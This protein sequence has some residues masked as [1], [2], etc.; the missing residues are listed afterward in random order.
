VLRRNNQW[1]CKKYRHAIRDAHAKSHGVLRGELTVSP[2]LPDHLRQGFFAKPATY[3]VVARFSTTAGAIRS[4]TIRGV[5]SNDQNL[6]MA[7]GLVT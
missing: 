4:D 1:A 7:L 5:R 2:G 3:P 6:W